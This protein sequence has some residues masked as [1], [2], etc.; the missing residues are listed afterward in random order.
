M[1]E[2]ILDQCLVSLLNTSLA[3][4]SEDRLGGI[5]VSLLGQDMGQLAAASTGRG[6]RQL[7]SLVYLIN[8][9]KQTV[10]F[11]IDS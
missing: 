6:I 1:S 7:L 10:Q 2:T 11:S 4:G 9:I 3:S 8:I 5:L